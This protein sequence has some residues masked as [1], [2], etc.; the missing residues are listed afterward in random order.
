MPFGL[1]TSFMSPPAFVILNF[2]V[3]CLTMTAN[4]F[5]PSI[6]TLYVPTTD[7]RVTSVATLLVPV[8][9]L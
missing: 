2:N 6:I 5:S 9:E 8:E 7:G 4:D 3:N 1:N